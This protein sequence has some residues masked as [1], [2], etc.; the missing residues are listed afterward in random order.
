MPFMIGGLLGIVLGVLVGALV[1]ALVAWDYHRKWQ[2][3]LK[4]E[5]EL[6][7]Q[8]QATYI[9]LA[10]HQQKIQLMQQQSDWL[11]QSS[12]QI[13]N[14]SN[15][16]L[17]EQRELMANKGKNTLE[18]TLKPFAEGIDKLRT[19]LLQT[20]QFATRERQE[21][22]TTIKMLNEQTSHVQSEAKQLTKALKGDSKMRGDWGEIL[23]EKVLE[24]SGLQ[25]GQGYEM[26]RQYRLADSE[27]KISA[28]RPDAVIHLPNERDIVID[29]KLTLNSWLEF[30]ASEDP[31]RQQT[32]KAFLDQV[33][34]EIKNLASKKYDQLTELSTV[35]F[36]F[37]FIPIEPAY[38]Y[39]AQE[40]PELL[41]DAFNKRIALVSPTTLLPLLRVIEHIWRLE[42]QNKNAQEIASQAGKMYDKFCQFVDRMQSV[43]KSLDRAQQQYTDSLNTLHTGRGN[44]VGRARKIQDLGANTTSNLPSDLSYEELPYQ[45]VDA[46]IESAPD[47]TTSEPLSLDPKAA[48]SEHASATAPVADRQA[49]NAPQLQPLKAGKIP[50]ENLQP[51]A[52]PNAAGAEAPDG[53]AS[54]PESLDPKAAGSEHASAT[55]PVADRQAE[56]APQLQPLKAGKIPPE[57]LQPRAVPDAAGAETPANPVQAE[58]TA[59]QSATIDYSLTETKESEN[60]QDNSKESENT[61]DKSTEIPFRFFPPAN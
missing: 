24:S 38:I 1:G 51:R 42:K 11:T 19:D 16:V 21:L 23:L 31:Q 43:G 49:E 15:S 34:K 47:D 55:A 13:A 25:K 12:D 32:G 39:I 9:E 33:R 27:G 2:L 26:Q 53:T 14:I 46:H 5:S 6:Q 4:K 54:E 59:A 41:Q 7:Q 8:L 37:M 50:P 10:S 61:Q 17:A 40:S 60:T 18:E 3:Q 35:D 28:M 48:G 22:Q 44:L 58:R 56:N 57:N 30:H 20:N 52:V 36:T 29:A 45:T